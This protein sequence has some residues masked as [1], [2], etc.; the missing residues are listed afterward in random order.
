MGAGRAVVDRQVLWSG[1]AVG[2]GVWSRRQSAPSDASQPQHCRPP[3]IRAVLP[4]LRSPTTSSS[5]V[6]PLSTRLTRLCL[7]CCPPCGLHSGARSCMP[8]STTRLVPRACEPKPLR[9]GTRNAAASFSW[10]T[11]SAC[12]RLAHVAG[13]GKGQGVTYR[14]ADTWMRVSGARRDCL[15]RM[16]MS[17]G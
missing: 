16:A 4:A 5:P 15:S 7:S 9:P 12:W 11:G 2:R 3:S 14:L 1:S 13:K 10:P 8:N 17:S 6:V